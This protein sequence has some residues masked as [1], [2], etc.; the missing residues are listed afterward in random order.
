[1]KPIHFHLGLH[2]LHGSMVRLRRYVE[3]GLPAVENNSERVTMGARGCPHSKVMLACTSS[4]ASA[5]DY[6][7][8]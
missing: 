1:M 7:K 6:R 5:G 2:C 3:R 4:T 8:L